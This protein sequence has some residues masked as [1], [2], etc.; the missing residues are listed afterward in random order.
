[1]CRIILCRILKNL[2]KLCLRVELCCVRLKEGVSLHS[3]PK[4]RFRVLLILPDKI[5]IFKEL[6]ILKVLRT[7]IDFTYK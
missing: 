2:M 6:T 4:V 7:L 1:M 5:R 3:Q